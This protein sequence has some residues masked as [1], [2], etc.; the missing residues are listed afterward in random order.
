LN[1]PSKTTC[2]IYAANRNVSQSG[3]WFAFS[4]RE[5]DAQLLWLEEEAVADNSMTIP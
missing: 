5:T 2:A 1:V 3:R 4:T